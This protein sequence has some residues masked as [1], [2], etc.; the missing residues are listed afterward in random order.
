MSPE[1]LSNLLPM[2]AAN[3][4]T[5]KSQRHRFARLLSVVSSVEAG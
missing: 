3:N 4:W 5:H 1:E 2:E